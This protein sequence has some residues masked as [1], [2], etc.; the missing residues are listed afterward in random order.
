[1]QVGELVERTAAGGAD[2]PFVIFRDRTITYGEMA[3]QVARFAGGL[4]ALGIQ[5]G[6]RVGLM[7][8]NVPEFIVAYYGILRAGAIVVS[9]MWLRCWFSTGM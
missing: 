7:A 4:R 9:R 1:M 3:E 6:E 8:H 2:R 5:E